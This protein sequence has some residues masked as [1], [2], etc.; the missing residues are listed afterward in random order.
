MITLIGIVKKGVEDF[1]KRIK[2]YPH[3]FKKATG[4]NLYPGTINVEVDRPIPI[5]EDFRIKGS[6]IGEPH[7]DLLFERCKINGVDAFR[8]RPYNLETGDGGHG[9][10]ILEISSSEKIQGIELEII[11][12][13]ALFREPNE[14]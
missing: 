2:E 12:E 5:D 1:R 3:V 4:V 9:D 8:I 14:I 13:I 7:Q 10:D 11:V 6:D